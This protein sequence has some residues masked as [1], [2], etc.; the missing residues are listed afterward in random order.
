M[1][2]R[3]PTGSYGMPQTYFVMFETSPEPGS[4]IDSRIDGALAHV[5][6]LESDPTSA[7]IK[8]SYKVRQAGWK[9]D[10]VETQP[11]AVDRDD[12]KN[13]DL[14]LKSFDECQQDGLSLVFVGYTDAEELHTDE[15]QPVPVVS[16]INL[17]EWLSDQK[18]IKDGGKCL[19]Y[20]VT[21]SCC[22][23]ID[24]HSIQ[25]G[26]ALSSI[27]VDGYVYSPSLSF[28]DIKKSKGK[29]SF[30]RTHINSFS[31]F[32]GLCMFHDNLVFQAIDNAPLKPTDEQA[33]LYAYR[34]ILKQLSAKN[35]VVESL[36]NQLSRFSGSTATREFMENSLKGNGMGQQ[37]LEREKS[38]FDE[39]HRRGNFSDIRYV[40][41]R[42]KIAPT[43]VFSGGFFPD[44]GFNGE[45]IQDLGDFTGDR[46]SMT[47]SSAPTE[48]SWGFLFAW[49]RSS[50]EVCRYFIS[51]LQQSIREGQN[52]GN[53]LFQLV[54]KGC[55]NTAFSPTWIEALNDDQKSEL[56]EAMTYGSD[57][58]K[59]PDGS[60]LTG[61]LEAPPDWEFTG[62]ED[63]LKRKNSA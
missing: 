43:V 38:H 11:V 44:W 34:S 55:E 12:F 56:I 48:D 18:K 15:P 63:N 5:W 24:A 19:F 6:V 28:G 41:F 50:D 62:V 45:P 32:R 54:V 1:T 49:H 59:A 7:M 53:L 2:N 10:K 25:R 17:H 52:L 8:A 35:F 20:D 4:A 29:A 37:Y 13:K 31:T 9:I 33:F 23:V 47:F 39:S 57:L 30:A 26:Q 16:E 61:G 51:T 36:R 60:Y 27:D 46:S 3:L 40:F 21:E 22:E 58:L 14:G 42:S